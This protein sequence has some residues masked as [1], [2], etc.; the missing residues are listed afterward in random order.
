MRSLHASL[1]L[2]SLLALSGSLQAQNLTYDVCFSGSQEVP[3]VATG[4][5]ALASVSLNVSTGGVVVNG[6]YSGL[7]GAQTLAHI[8][9]APVGAN[10]PAIVTL[11]GSGGTGGF[12]SGVGTLTA[13]QVTSMLAGDTYINIHSAAHAGGELRGQIVQT[14]NAGCPL[15]DGLVPL[16]TCDVWEH[17][18]YIDYRNARPKYVDAFW[19]LVN[20]DFAA[21]NL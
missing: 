17:A 8:H 12:F 19:S 6:S 7:N 20:W 15:T 5:T 16:L 9:L 11:S 21:S 18:Y 2:A 10:G 14:T 1:A 4:G 3:A 13:P